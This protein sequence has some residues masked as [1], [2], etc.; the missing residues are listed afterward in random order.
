MYHGAE[1]EANC[2][3]VTGE[4]PEEIEAMPQTV[5]VPAESLLT[6]TIRNFCFKKRDLVQTHITSFPH[7]HVFMVCYITFSQCRVITYDK[8]HK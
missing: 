2:C 5:D 8:A 7:L 6:I 4:H 3:E 1:V